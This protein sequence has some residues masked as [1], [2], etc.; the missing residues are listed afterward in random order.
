MKTS[1]TPEEIV[2]ACFSKM[3]YP[4][5][6]DAWGMAREAQVE[7]LLAEHVLN[8]LVKEGKAYQDGK[9][10]SRRPPRLSA[11]CQH[12]PTDTCAFC[13]PVKHTEVI[14]ESNQLIS[15]GEELI[16]TSKSVVVSEG[17]FW[18]DNDLGRI[19]KVLDPLFKTN[20]GEHCVVYEEIDNPG[21]GI[22]YLPAGT[23]VQDFTQQETA[24]CLGCNKT[25]PKRVMHKTMVN[26]EETVQ[27]GSVV[28]SVDVELLS[29]F[30]C[31]RKQ[32]TDH[33]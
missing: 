16:K 5:A 26:Y 21:E 29:C 2:R 8:D 27:A 13:D 17:S 20:K 9:W 22:Y 30:P 25:F 10:Y 24:I 28:P 19:V 3:K 12:G 6:I 18:A 23:F 31:Y 1:P 11:N 33:E 4:H 32:E 14:K 7:P 15:M